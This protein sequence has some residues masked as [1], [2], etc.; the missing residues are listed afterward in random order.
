MEINNKLECTHVCLRMY[1]ERETDREREHL[2]FIEEGDLCDAILVTTI[3]IL[4]FS[5]RSCIEEHSKYFRIYFSQ[6]YW[7]V[8]LFVVFFLS[9][10]INTSNCEV[11]TNGNHITKPFRA[12]ATRRF[13]GKISVFMKITQWNY[14]HK[15]TRKTD[16]HQFFVLHF[17]FFF[18]C[19]KKENQMQ[20]KWME[21][22]KEPFS[23][24]Y[25]LWN[26]WSITSTS[27]LQFCIIQQMKMRG[28]KKKSW[29]WLG[30]VGL[31]GEYPL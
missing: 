11:E 21:F 30:W 4:C 7:C 28:K 9:K 14:A 15:S 27:L 22:K 8:C 29:F 20:M 3:F 19:K 17:F 18:F 16:C 2:V 31:G 13:I 12:Q 1:S 10:M 24:F 6:K 26:L 5:H 25:I 23:T